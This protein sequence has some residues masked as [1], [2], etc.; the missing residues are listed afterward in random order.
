MY[1]RAYCN[2]VHAGTTLIG[3]YRPVEAGVNRAWS[4]CLVVLHPTTQF[5]GFT[6]EILGPWLLSLVTLA[7][8]HR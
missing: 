5:G 8:G 1:Y 4:G 6:H 7:A 3:G 2:G